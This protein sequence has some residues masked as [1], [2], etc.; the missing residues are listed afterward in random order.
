MET[1]TYLDFRKELKKY[2]D[3]ATEDAEP[4]IIT[5]KENRNAVLISEKIYNNMIENQFVLGNPTN[6]KWLE[7]SRR[8]VGSFKI[9]QHDLTDFQNNSNNDE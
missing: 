7:K 6:L 8:Q 1:I 4:I 9:S 5:R 2:F 3:K